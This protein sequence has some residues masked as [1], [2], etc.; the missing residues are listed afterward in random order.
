M[1]NFKQLLGNSSLFITAFLLSIQPGVLANPTAITSLQSSGVTIEKHERN[2]KVSFIGSNSPNG[3]KLP[4]TFSSLAANSQEKARDFVRAYAPLFGVDKPN[5]DLAAKKAFIL[6][7]QPVVKYQQLYNGI[8]VFAAEINV[9]LDKSGNLLSMSGEAAP[10]L[11]LSTTAKVSAAQALNTALKIVQK[12]YKLSASSVNATTPQLQVYQPGLI[13]P[14]D[15]PAKLVWFI[16]VTPKAPK[17]IQQIVLVDAVAPERVVRSWNNNPDVRTRQTYTASETN[18]LP[19]ILL[20]NET[21]TGS[22]CTTGN[23]D[24][25]KAHVYAGNTYNFYLNNHGRDGIDGYGLPIISTV[26][27]YDSSV[28][29]NAFW[30]GNQMVYCDS[31]VVDDVVGHELTHGVTQYTSN[32]FYYYQ[33][34]AMNESFSDVWGEF[35]D[36]TNG[37]GNDSSAVRWKIGEDIPTS[38]FGGPIRDM[39]N[40]PLYGNPD[41]MTSSNYYKG[42]DDNGGVHTNSGINNKAVYLM[43]DGGTFNGQTI[44]GIGI[45]KVAKIYYKVQTTLLT[46][47]S[48]YNDLY[49]YLYQSCQSQIGTAGITASNCTQVRNATLAVEM[50]KQPANGYQPQASLCPAGKTPSNVFFDNVEGSNKWNFLTLIGNNSWKYDTSYAAS[51]T[52]SLIIDD[53]AD[54]PTDSAAVQKTGVTIPSGALLHFKHAFDFEFDSSSN[55]DAAVLEYSIGGSGVWQDAQPLF[56]E[57]Q[58]YNGTVYS[59]SNSLAGRSA[60]TQVSHGYVSSKY[61]LSRLAG[62]VVRFR[63]RQ[64]NDPAVGARGWNVDDV[65]VYTCK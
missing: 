37:Q 2:G 53:V 33:S 19:G 50:N 15:G 17:P 21:T 36:L 54:G 27:F 45:T 31:L 38:L 56:V 47:G 25:T 6:D 58:N 23:N 20:C 7:S 16:Q 5:T 30:D 41:K 43:T 13:D 28:C 51:G 59:G 1:T 62:K 32:L 60:F 18:T 9:N 61:N 63:F 29:P 44:T 48:S 49:N 55:Y 11:T 46:S 22:G 14:G 42:S 40:P 52:N 35:I 24:S 8:P 10:D 64:A 39:K 57:G 4:S 26:Q 65:R 34:G 3:I 12:Q